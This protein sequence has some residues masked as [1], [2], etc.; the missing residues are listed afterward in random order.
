MLRVAW[1]PSEEEPERIA[2]WDGFVRYLERRLGVPVELI[3]TGNYGAK[4]EAMRAHKIE[5]CTLG[6]F[7]YVVARTK[8]AVEPM[9]VRGERDGAPAV[10]RSIFIVPA[11]SPLRSLEDVVSR[12]GEL[13]LAWVDPASASG[14]LVPRV[15]LE[16][17]GLVPEEHF[18]EVVFTLSHLAS[19]LST[20]AGHVDLA[21]VTSNGLDRFVRE[22]RIDREDVRV[23]WASD[24]I[25]N[26]V[27]AIR[28]DLPESFKT[29]VR[30]AWLSFREDEPALWTEF[31]DGFPDPSTIW[32]P[33]ADED[34]DGLREVARRLRHLR[35]L[36]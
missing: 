35:L 31:A 12:A 7:S 1:T 2:R 33:I 21:A 16:S 20:K 5:V 17:L 19:V 32:V 24:S 30:E 22:G 28:G 18:K 25:V 29:R 26:D 14:H 36:E 6:P 11:S 8:M 27:T 34:F 9:V 13:T 15:H 4:I 10:Y 23:L 3:Q